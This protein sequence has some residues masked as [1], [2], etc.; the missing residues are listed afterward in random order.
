ME[1]VVKRRD[2]VQLLL[3]AAYTLPLPL[4]CRRKGSPEVQAVAVARAVI[5]YQLHMGCQQASSLTRQRQQHMDFLLE[6]QV[7]LH[8]LLLQLRRRMGSQPGP[9]FPP[10][11]AAWA[12]QLK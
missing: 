11:T 3:L 7:P 4:R 12:A 1:F 10:I 5:P 8:V 2:F 6:L 9:E